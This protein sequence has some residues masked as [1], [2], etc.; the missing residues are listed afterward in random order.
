MTNNPTL[1]VILTVYK[2]ETLELQLRTIF[3]QSWKPNEILIWQN[4][5]HINMSPSTEC[6][7]AYA[8]AGIPLRHIHSK[9]FNFK[10]HG[11]FTL[12]LLLTTD[13]VAIFDDDTPPGPLW[14]ENCL[15]TSLEFNC[16]V[17]GNGRNIA[18]VDPITLT[19]TEGFQARAGAQKVDFIGHCW[20][21]KQKW[22]KHMW[23]H[24]PSTLENGEDIHFSASL[25]LVGIPSYCPSQPVDQPGCWGD[26]MPQ[27]HG[28]AHASYKKPGHTA[29]RNDII[30][31]W[32][33]KGWKLLISEGEGN[34]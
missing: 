24:A 30:N 20:F 13:Y 23:A 25:S 3:D 31:H 5:S 19:G 27:Y 22:I 17:G 26:I 32:I 9:Q 11:R 33:K 6:L 14:L 8:A 7:A 12:P 10:F 34:E 2:R 18:T 4:E 21:F 1:S 15:Q 16:A 29:E 28:D